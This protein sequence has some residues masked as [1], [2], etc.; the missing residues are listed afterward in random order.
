MAE[1]Q[2]A[3]R[4]QPLLGVEKPYSAQLLGRVWAIQK[5]SL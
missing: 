2:L 3:G 4:A 1:A 5:V